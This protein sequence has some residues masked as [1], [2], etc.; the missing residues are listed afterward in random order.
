MPTTRAGT[1]LAAALVLY[2]FA[3][4]TQ[5][6]WLYVMSALLAGVVLAAFWLGRGGLRRIEGERSIG[7]RADAQLYEG[8]ELTITFILSN[9]GRAGAAQMRLRERCPLA[10]PDAPQ[11]EM[12]LYVPSLP[13]KAHVQFEY[14][15]VAD[16]RGLHQF[17]P[18]PLES[19]APFGFFRRARTLD[20][21]TRALVYPEVRPLHHLDFLD[22]QYAPQIARPT[23]GFGYEVMG[24]RPY[25]PGDSPR[26]V[27]WRSVARTGQM[28]TKEFADETQPGL[29]LALDLGKHPYPQAS[30]KHT[31]FEWGVKAA[32]SISDY[33]AHKGYPLSLITNSGGLPAPNGTVTQHMVLEYLA[34][35][36]PDGDA[37]LA[38]LL[39]NGQPGAFL[40]VIL[41]W[42]DERLVRTLVDLHQRNLHVLAVVIDAATFPEGGPS[43]KDAAGELR[44][45]GVDVRLL[46]F[47]DDW[48]GQI[49]G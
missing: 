13:S 29:A 5:V 16:R 1:V 39:A 19:S 25:R 46:H 45:A 32:A 31:A 49:Q 17:P 9:N 23:A 44:A 14:N 34:R 10:A 40:A 3:N 28:V 22:R 18:L 27:H 30:S 8:D 11:H 42:P 24:L 12:K 35:V 41:P 43:A 2:F 6:G 36:Q 7:G 21:P 20:V 4:Q 33:A 48:A 26:H 15:V 47:S 38:A 37:P